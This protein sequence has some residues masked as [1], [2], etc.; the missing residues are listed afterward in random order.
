[1]FKAEIVNGKPVV[2]HFGEL[3]EKGFNY[4]AEAQERAD[5]LN[6]AQYAKSNQDANRLG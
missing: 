4:L 5:E 1:M 3:I 6:E 2:L